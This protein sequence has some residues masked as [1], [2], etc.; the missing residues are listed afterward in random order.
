MVETKVR[1]LENIM[2]NKK[3]VLREWIEAIFFAGTLVFVIRTFIF[4]LYH[5]PTGS[6]EPTILAGERLYAN[7]F[8][9]FFNEIKHGD[10]IV[11]NDPI[12]I[13]DKNPI[14]HAY[15]KYVGIG[16]PF[17]LPEGPSNWTKRVIG[18]PGDT[19]EGRLENGV[20]EIY[21]NGEK[22]QEREYLNPYPLILVQ[23]TIG[24]LDLKN[25]GPII[26]PDFIRKTKKYYKYT[27]EPDK[28][29]D[30]QTFYKLKPYEVVRD[31]YFNSILDYPYT[32]TYDNDRCIDEFG[33]IKIPKNKY[34]LMGD[35]RKG[36]WDSRFWGF[37][38]KSEIQGKVNF[39][40]YSIDSQEPFLFFDF[41]KHPIDFWT[42]I[43]WN[44]FFK[45]VK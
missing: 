45:S 29:F 15:Q 23:R 17:L 8:T 21:R 42:Q 4:G 27:Y 43:R 41:I 12:F 28:H 32:P 11:I 22:L 38:D 37:C 33:P 7:K 19:I 2:E 9:Y 36:S 26:I 39:I 34:W 40:I 5:V 31:E 24:L 20:P 35:N 13:Y 10:Y 3:S 25:I 1:F 30:E 44:R 18:I 6:A 14:I 16:I